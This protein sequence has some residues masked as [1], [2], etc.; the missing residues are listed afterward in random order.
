MASYSSEESSHLWPWGHAGPK[1]ESRLSAGCQATESPLVQG[2]ADCFL[3]CLF[4]VASDD[5]VWAWLISR[6]WN[7]GIITWGGI[8][9]YQILTPCHSQEDVWSKGRKS[10]CIW[11]KNYRLRGA[12]KFQKLS[13]SSRHFGN[14]GKGTPPGKCRQCGLIGWLW[15]EDG[16][17]GWWDEEGL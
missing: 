5:P 17:L 15:I 7:K 13:K 2:L 16:T 4:A 6:I 3:K 8:G 14:F 12:L 9:K 10:L 11:S 1:E